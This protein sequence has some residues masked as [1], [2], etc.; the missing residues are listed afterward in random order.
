MLRLSCSTAKVLSHGGCV[1]LTCADQCC[2]PAVLKQIVSF[3]L[4]F[5]GSWGS[6]TRGA[7]HMV[8]KLGSY[9][10]VGW[11]FC[12]HL[13]VVIFWWFFFFFGWCG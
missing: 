13:L 2:I 11:G 5:R 12:G 6:M 4:C 7:Q 1:M 3:A 9:F 8:E 10:I